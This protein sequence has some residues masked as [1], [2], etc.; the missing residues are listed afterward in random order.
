MPRSDSDSPEPR[1]RANRLTGSG[2]PETD[3]AAVA[4]SDEVESLAGRS[5]D[6]RPFPGREVYSR[7]ELQV[8]EDTT[9]F[10]VRDKVMA[11]M[12]RSFSDLR[13]RLTS[14]L[15]KGHY[16]APAGVDYRRGKVGQGEHLDGLPYSFVDLPRYITEDECFTYRAL[17]WWGD[18]VS[19]SLILGGDHLGIYRRR[20]LENL[21]ILSALGVYV[22]LADNPWD[23]QRGKG[24]TVRAQPGKEPDLLRAFRKQ[25]FLKCSRFLEFS[26][27][28]FRE[29][30]IDEA[31]LYTFQVLEPLVLS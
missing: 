23:W 13:T 30:R 27:S 12:E 1:G 29:N 2:S 16:L 3:D 20:L 28:D 8:L 21:E 5:S 4:P 22:S 18:G 17:F 6:V 14:H 26:D 24:L 15:R 10:R 19:F 31:G 7:E 25:S 9:P 11:S